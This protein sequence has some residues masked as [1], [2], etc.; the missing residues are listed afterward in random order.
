MSEQRLTKVLENNLSKY[1]ILEPL[2]KKQRRTLPIRFLISW[3]YLVLT[4][5]FSLAATYITTKIVFDSAEER[6]TNQLI[7]VGKL[8]SE[9]MVLEEDSL[10]ET[11][12]LVINTIGLPEEVQNAEIDN[13]H[14]L[15]YPLAVNAQIENIEILNLDG[16][17][18]YSLQHQAGSTLEDYQTTTGG[19]YFST[20]NI[21]TSIL[22]GNSDEFG[23]K[24]AAP[25]NPPWGSIFYVAGP[26]SNQNDLIGIALVGKSLPSL[27]KDMRETTLAQTTI[28]NL[29][30]RELSTSF[31]TP[32]EIEPGLVSQVLAGQDLI[33][34]TQNKSVADIAYTEI[35]A[36]WEARNDLDIGILG[37]A[38]PQ[39]YLVQTSWVTRTQI[40]IALGAFIFLVLFAGYRLSN[41]ISKP[42]ESLA[43]ASE[44]VAKG[45]FLVTLESPGSKE[46]AILTSSFNDMLKSLEDSQSELTEAYDNSLQGWSRALSL[47]DHD[48]DKH[49]K[50][51]V[52]LTVAFASDLGLDDK[53]FENIRRGALLHDLGKMAIPDGILRKNGPLSPEEWVVMKQHPLHAVEMLKPVRFLEDALEIPLYHHEQWDGSG[54]PYGL[55]GE[56]IPLA[57]RIFAVADV[58]DAL[59]SNRPYRKAWSKQQAIEY[60]LEMKGKQFDPRL[61]DHFMKK[62][63]NKA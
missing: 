59:L 36:P 46:V 8:S 52:E 44:E 32:Q 5:F 29:E 6:Y 61:V 56:E 16:I 13:L 58:Y 51:V 34:L 4:I 49:S 10:L 26:I 12:R 25:L 55:K 43:K 17:T 60:L 35:L 20:T 54:Y 63:V 30:G 39:N 15:I 53:S 38:I 45:N 41:Q 33:S 27:V 11:L 50:R 1:D 18:V 42:L 48:T 14:R 23:D 2:Q 19:D 40:F 62:F 9:W 7:E 22:Q 21:V 31:I 47:R 28:Y 57:A 3:P 37:S 24:Y